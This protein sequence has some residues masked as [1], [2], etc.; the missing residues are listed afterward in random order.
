MAREARTVLSEWLGLNDEELIHR[1]EGLG[2]QHGLDAL[3]MDLVA[4]DRHFFVRQVAAKKIEDHKLL[5]EH[6]TDRNVGQILV[7]GVSRSEDVAYLQELVRQTRHADV[8]AVAEA[9]LKSTTHAC[10]P[11]VA[12]AGR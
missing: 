3:L 6:W 8:R 12:G 1:I 5:H 10:R 2:K 7:R 9:Q 11:S 4:S